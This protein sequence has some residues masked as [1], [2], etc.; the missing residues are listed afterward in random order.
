MATGHDYVEDAQKY[1]DQQAADKQIGGDQEGNTGVTH[2]AHVHQGEQE[3][4]QQAKA[5]CMRLQLGQGRDQRSYARG[6]AYRRRQYVVDHQGG[7]GQ[8]S[9]VFSQ[10]R[11][12]HRIGS[13]AAGISLDG[14]TI[15]EIND[16]Q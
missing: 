12:R 3:K 16:D 14:L 9:G 15:G 6:D 11:R 2:A 7:G 5:E 4:N 13:P 10:V 8:Q 1:D